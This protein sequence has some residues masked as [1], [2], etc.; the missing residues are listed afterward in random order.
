[1]VQAQSMDMKKEPGQGVTWSGS[2]ADRAGEGAVQAIGSIISIPSEE[3][4]LLGG[5]T[6]QHVQLLPPA[7]Q[8]GFQPLSYPQRTEYQNR[9]CAVNR[10][11]TQSH[12]TIQTVFKGLVCLISGSRIALSHWKSFLQH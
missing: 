4:M 9:S 8:E 3:H 1:M 10:E 11:L 5:L 12:D 2:A 7:E 6:S